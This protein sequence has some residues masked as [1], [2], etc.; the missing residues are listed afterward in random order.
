M[1][2]FINIKPST[3]TTDDYE[4]MSDRI[5]AIIR[6]HGSVDDVEHDDVIGI[7]AQINTEKLNAVMAILNV[8]KLSNNNLQITLETSALPDSVLYTFSSSMRRQPN[9]L[10]REGPQGYPQQQFQTGPTYSDPVFNI[11]VQFKA[12]QVEQVL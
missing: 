3:L 6:K 1:Q 7:E 8:L 10:W 4:L 5:N 2:T 11:S 12:K 9:Q